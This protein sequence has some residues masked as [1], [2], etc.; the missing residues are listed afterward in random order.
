MNQECCRCV[1]LALHSADE[2]YGREYNVPQK[3][4]R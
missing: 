2:E 3:L 4:D 1:L